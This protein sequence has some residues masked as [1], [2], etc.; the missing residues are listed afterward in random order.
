MTVDP[1]ALT[2][3]FSAVAF[4]IACRFELREWAEAC[5]TSQPKVAAA[6]MIF[7]SRH[8]LRTAAGAA[9]VAADL[10]LLLLLLLSL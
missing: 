5:T 8:K 7:S 3:A 9:D 1:A 2:I 10:L 4:S 6:G